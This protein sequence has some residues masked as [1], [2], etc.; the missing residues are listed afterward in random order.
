MLLNAI[1]T[2]I[3]ICINAYV[4]VFVYVD[5]AEY[6]NVH[7]ESLEGWMKGISLKIVGG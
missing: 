7:I 5:A 6:V 3:Q 4:L 2:T 1:A